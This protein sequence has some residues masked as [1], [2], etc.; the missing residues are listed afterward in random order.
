[1]GRKKRLS[2]QNEYKTL[3]IE[4]ISNAKV[5]N[6]LKL[7]KTNARHQGL[8]LEEGR[9]RKYNQQVS[10]HKLFQRNSFSDKLS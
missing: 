9:Y 3:T 6:E 5:P 1:M 4:L 10:G 8:Q 7:R 2:S